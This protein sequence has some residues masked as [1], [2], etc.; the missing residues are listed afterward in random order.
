MYSKQR[1][2]HEVLA[3]L[4]KAIGKGFVIHIEDLE[5]P[6]NTDMG[7]IAYPCFELAKSQ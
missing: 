2:K 7:D 1:A 4:K 5:T 3:A 6:P